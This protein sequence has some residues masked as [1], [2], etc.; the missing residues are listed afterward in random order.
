[1]AKERKGK[2]GSEVGE[3]PLSMY[4]EAPCTAHC[5]YHSRA[6]TDARRRPRVLVGV[7]VPAGQFPDRGLIN[8]CVGIAGDHM[9]ALEWGQEVFRIRH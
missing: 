4:I 6:D 5:N 2:G 8:R 7:L 9:I 3:S 1:M